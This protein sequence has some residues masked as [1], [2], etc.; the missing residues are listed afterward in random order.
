MLPELIFTDSAAIAMIRAS[1]KQ[2]TVVAQKTR[3]NSLKSPR[4]QANSLEIGGFFG[5]PFAVFK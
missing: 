2:P 4:D 1:A 5:L 3:V